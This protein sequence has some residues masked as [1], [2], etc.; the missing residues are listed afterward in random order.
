MGSGE[1]RPKTYHVFHTLAAHCL[2]VA[3]LMMCCVCR[4]EQRQDEKKKTQEKLEQSRS[5]RDKMRSKYQ[6][7]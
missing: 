6:R 3:A 4:E 5:M 2:E 1:N 7:G